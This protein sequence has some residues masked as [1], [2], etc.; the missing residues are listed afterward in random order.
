MFTLL[1][2]AAALLATTTAPALAAGVDGASLSIL[3]AVP[4]VGMLLSIAIFPLANPHF[5]EHH[6]G[7]IAAFWAALTMIPLALTAGFGPALDALGHTILLE[8][9]P[10]ILLIFVL[11]TVAAAS[12]SAATSMARR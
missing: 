10:F 7:K 8:Y 11:F 5:W 6:Q 2:S 12:G 1:A 4:F 9:I 3:W